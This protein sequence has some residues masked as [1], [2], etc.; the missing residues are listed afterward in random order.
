MPLS[1]RRPSWPLLQL[2]S[3]KEGMQLLPSRTQPGHAAISISLVQIEQ[4]G[5]TGNTGIF[6]T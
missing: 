5:S 4:R 6:L 3:I 1:T 2:H